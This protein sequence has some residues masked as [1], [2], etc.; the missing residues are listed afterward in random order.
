MTTMTAEIYSKPAC[1]Y[2]VRA[3]ELM[4]REGIEFTEIAAVE[5][6]DQLIERVTKDS[7]RA[8]TTL[9]QIYVNGNYV[10]GYTEL[11]EYL[12]NA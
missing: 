3:K 6:R 5:N 1:G 2:C 11:V 4:K 12:K 7:G 10:G 8:P 9:P